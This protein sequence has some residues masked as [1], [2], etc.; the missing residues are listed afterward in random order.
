MRFPVLVLTLHSLVLSAGC[1]CDNSTTFGL[2]QT[3]ISSLEGQALSDYLERLRECHRCRYHMGIRVNYCTE[4]VYWRLATIPAG[5]LTFGQLGILSYYE[6]RCHDFLRDNDLA[7]DNTGFDPA[8]ARSL[9]L[10]DYQPPINPRG[11]LIGGVSLLG[12]GLI[13]SIH[14]IGNLYDAYESKGYEDDWLGLGETITKIGAVIYVVVAAV[15]DI[16][17]SGLTTFAVYKGLANSSSEEEYRRMYEALNVSAKPT[18]SGGGAMVRFCLRYPLRA[19][20]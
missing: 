2:D 6:E 14:S 18:E 3:V 20:R 10:L 11:F 8:R 4:P 16:A 17:G 12:A 13:M 15:A 5:S 1:P 19:A 7:I 9:P